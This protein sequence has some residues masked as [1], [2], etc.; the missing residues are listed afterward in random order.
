MHTQE[1]QTNTRISGKE[2]H[3][4]QLVTLCRPTEDGK[5]RETRVVSKVLDDRVIL[6]SPDFADKVSVKW[7]YYQTW[8]I[9]PIT[10]KSGF[11]V[12]GY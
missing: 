2:F 10:T 4:F 9:R 12:Y 5:V 1:V 6:H 7:S 3:L 11:P 8:N